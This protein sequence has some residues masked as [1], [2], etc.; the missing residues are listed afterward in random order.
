MFIAL[1]AATAWIA[2]NA[3]A[4]DARAI[5]RLMTRDD[6]RRLGLERAWF[7]QVELDRS[8]HRVERA[9]LKD[10]RL[11]VLTTAGVVQDFNALTGER[12]WTAPV[13]N[14]NYP[15]LGPAASDKYVAI[16]NGST[17]YVLRRQDGK[18]LFD[19]RVVGGAP[20]AAPAVSAEYVFVPLIN[21]RFEGYPLNQ[22]A[23]K[24]RTPWY[25][26]SNGRAMVAPLATPESVIW[27]TDRGHM[28]V[29][30]SL[31]PA[32]RFRLESASDIIAS[33]AYHR[34]LVYA[35]T[36]GGDLYALNEVN[37]AR[38]W[39]YST[40]YQVERA[41]AAVGDRVYVTTEEPAMHCV[42]AKTGMALWVAPKIIQFAAA[43]DK[44]VYGI[45]DLRA[46]VVLDSKT[47][48]LLDRMPT[49]GT[50][51]AL[52]NDQTDR[53][54][55]ISSGGLLQ[56]LYEIGAKKPLY[57]NPPPVE[58]P[59]PEP[60]TAPGPATTRESTTTEG[61]A[62]P[63]AGEGAAP[64]AGGG[65]DPFSGLNNGAAGEGAEQPGQPPAGDGNFGV[66]DDNPF[67]E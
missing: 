7:S 11:T 57:H 35:A 37:G 59:K 20:G 55:L 17:L 62:P 12:L 31:S 61:A 60:G 48:A 22:G 23:D 29:A 38:K 4:E 8:R 65:V 46:L 3:L 25:Y 54:Y 51:N 24:S 36:T 42:D 9:I 34:P 33:P 47:G 45:D 39:K 40:G 66:G 64:P 53:L 27:S 49:D 44:R 14:A 16:V 28:Y 63:A 26:Q 21:G 19:R 50:A 52:V 32:V 13:G 41:P 56:C 30:A 18:P 2:W 67:G 10:D 6:A 43:S 5:E 15:S 58:E 1:A